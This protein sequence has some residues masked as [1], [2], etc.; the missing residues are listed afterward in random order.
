[1]KRLPKLFVSMT[2]L[3]AVLVL[4]MATVFAASETDWSSAKVQATGSGVAPANAVNVAQ[5]RLMARRAA[6]VDAYRQV[7][8]QVAGVQVDANTTVEMAMTTNDTIRTQVSGV[9]RGYKIVK[10]NMT[11]DGAYEVT[12]EV[13]MFGATGSLASAVLP[14]NTTVTAFPSVDTSVTPSAIGTYDTTI[15]GTTTQP[16]S[17]SSTSYASAAPGGT[18]NGSFTGLIVD[19]RGLGTLNPVMSPVIKNANGQA[20]YGYKNLDSA[21]VIA[22]GMASYAKSM[23]QATRAGSNPL[24]VKAVSLADHN[25]N[26]VLSVADANRVLIENGATHFLDNTNVVFLR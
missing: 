8:E 5:G 24:V 1:M 20:I 2:A 9:I 11:S 15:G 22:N 3:L 23:S 16:F 17:G 26:P 25:A 12:I 6:L 18:A 13:P 10:E 19:C 14:Q 4:S 7:V 21:K